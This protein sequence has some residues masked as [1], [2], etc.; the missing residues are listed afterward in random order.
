MA[1][2]V[3]TGRGAHAG[4]LVRNA[5]A[6]ELMEKVDTLVLDKTGTLTEGK[7]RMTSIAAIGGI[8]QVDLLLLVAAVEKLSEH[9]VAAAIVKEAEQRR[10]KI[11]QAGNSSPLLAKVLREKFWAGKSL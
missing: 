7:P 5:E 10:L 9:P 2:M 4:V 3:G 8:S 11:P 6:L 1:V